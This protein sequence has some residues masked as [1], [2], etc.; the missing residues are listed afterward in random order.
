MSKGLFVSFEGP[1]GGGKS[2]MLKRTAEWLIEN[3][4]EVL[5][6]REPGG[7][8]LGDYIRD[9]L[10]HDSCGESPTNAAEVLLFLAS[11]AQHVE[12]VIEPALKAGKIVLCDRFEDSTFAYQSYGRGYDLNILL[13]LNKFAT[14]GYSPSIVFVL[15]IGLEDSLNRMNK[16]QI[17]TNTSADRIELAGKE[18]HHR[19][20]DG[21]LDLQ[22]KEP[23]RKFLIDASQEENMVWE[24][25]K[26][27]LI[28]KM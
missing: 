11:R 7:T 14:S 17:Q 5:C 3:G 20:R 16:R 23:N 9:M 26:S 13:N 1:E 6:T 4:K 25:V 2:T 19:V 28:N 22:K 10:K 24:Q 18:F 27:I 15:D 21:F 8:K 12:K